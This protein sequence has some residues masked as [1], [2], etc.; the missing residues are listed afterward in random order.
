V[1]DKISTWILLL[2][3]LSGFGYMVYKSYSNTFK[4]NSLGLLLIIT[5]LIEFL[6][7]G[8]IVVQ[9]GAIARYRA[10]VYCLMIAGI[11][12]QFIKKNKKNQPLTLNND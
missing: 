11:L 8:L 9:H 4:L 7:I 2:F 6:I 3:T 12:S 5:S 1:P 10:P